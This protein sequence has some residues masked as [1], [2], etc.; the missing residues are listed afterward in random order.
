MGVKMHER[1]T[2]DHGSVFHGVLCIDHKCEG[3]DSFKKERRRLDMK[4]NNSRIWACPQISFVWIKNPSYEC[5]F[6]ST[7]TK[8][9]GFEFHK[10]IHFVS[11]VQEVS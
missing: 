11:V 2:I 4:M 7:S 9:C 6:Y 10:F 5:V 1:V 3:H 8:K